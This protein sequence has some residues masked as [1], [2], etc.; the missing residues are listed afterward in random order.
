[1][2]K[3]INSTPFYCML[4]KFV[5]QIRKYLIYWLYIYTMILRNKLK[6]G[7]HIVESQSIF[8]FITRYHGAAW[9]QFVHFIRI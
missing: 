4:Y 1:M 7:L 2:K 6:N 5:S 8:Q 9:Y 3:L